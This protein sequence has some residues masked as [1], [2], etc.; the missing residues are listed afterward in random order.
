MAPSLPRWRPRASAR[1]PGRHGVQ[2]NLRTIWALRGGRLTA[3]P[4]TFRTQLLALLIKPA[5]H[6]GR[7]SA[8]QT[9]PPG[10]KPAQRSPSTARWSAWGGGGAPALD[11]T[12]GG[13]RSLATPAPLTACNRSAW[14]SSHP[15]APGRC[16]LA[17]DGGHFGHGACPKNE[18]LAMAACASN[19]AGRLRRSKTLWQGGGRLNDAIFHG[20][21]NARTLA[22]C[23]I[24]HAQSSGGRLAQGALVSFCCCGLQKGHTRR[25]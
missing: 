21:T 23:T 3:T 14:R 20:C 13:G 12:P 18:E 25:S 7:P 5:T 8:Y 4:L 9:F 10:R 2:T 1:T 16:L 11:C 6:T 24:T 19:L 15:G 17:A 22:T